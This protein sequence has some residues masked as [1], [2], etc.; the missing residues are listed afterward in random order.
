MASCW[1]A[2]KQFAPQA[3]LYLFD[4]AGYGQVPV[5]VL[6]HDV[7]LVAGW[8]DKIFD[9]LEALEDS[10]SALDQINAIEL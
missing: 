4:L 10:G 8:S 9:V 2:Y 7:Y 6:Q 3:K 1:N 5:D